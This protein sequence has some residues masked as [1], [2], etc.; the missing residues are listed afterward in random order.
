MCS[1][2][3]GPPSFHWLPACHNGRWRFKQFQFDFWPSRAGGDR[4]FIIAGL[5]KE[6]GWSKT[7]Q[8]RSGIFKQA[9]SRNNAVEESLPRMD[10]DGHGYNLNPLQNRPSAVAASRKSAAD[11]WK[12]KSSAFSRKPLRS[13][14]SGF[15]LL[16]PSLT[17]ESVNSIFPIRVYPCPSVVELNRSG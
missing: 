12:L 7:T 14:R 16:K 4:E 1:T 9:L 10:T 8:P 11:I 3:T 15:N 5:N 2:Q 6:R 13:L 17:A